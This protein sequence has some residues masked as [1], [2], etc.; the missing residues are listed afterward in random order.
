MIL[1]K[2]G[3]LARHNIRKW[4]DE[5]KELNLVPKKE[6]KFR[7]NWICGIYRNFTDVQENDIYNFIHEA[8][9]NRKEVNL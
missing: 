7:K 8:R 6:H 3:I 2:S 9:E 1:K 5:E 4:G